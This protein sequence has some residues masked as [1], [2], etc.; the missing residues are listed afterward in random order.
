L[1]KLAWLLLLLDTDWFVFI[2]PTTYSE[3]CCCR[4]MSSTFRH[5]TG[6]V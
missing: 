2:E 5:L 1:A 3:C 4:L 6:A